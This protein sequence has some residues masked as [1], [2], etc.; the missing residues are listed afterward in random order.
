MGHRWFVRQ[1]P[2]S[3]S[4]V[5]RLTLALT[6]AAIRASL[7]QGRLS[8]PTQTVYITRVSPTS[9]SFTADQWKTVQA[10]L[11]DWKGAIERIRGSVE[12]GL[13]G[14]AGRKEVTVGGGADE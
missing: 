6:F 5:Y 9:S 10:R 2:F 1:L 14:A 3:R 4:P 13:S 12:R 8:Q 7:L 11:E